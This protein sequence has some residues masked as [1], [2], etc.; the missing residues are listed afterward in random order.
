ME[1]HP[2]LR[3]EPRRDAGYGGRTELSA[4]RLCPPDGAGID[5]GEVRAGHGFLWRPARAGLQVGADGRGAAESGVLAVAQRHG[6]CADLGADAGAALASCPQRGEGRR[7]GPRLGATGAGGWA[8]RGIAR[9]GWRLDR[10]RS[11]GGTAA[12][13]GLGIEERP[14][15]GGAGGSWKSGDADLRSDVAVPLWG[16]RY[17][18]PSVLGATAALGGWR[19]PAVRHGGGA[20]GHGPVDLRAGTTRGGEGAADGCRIPRVGEWQGQSDP[21]EGGESGGLRSFGIPEGFPGAL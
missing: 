5:S 9:D 16:G 8:G 14:G 19:K 13:E 6:E 4:A 11:R 12:A 1:D 7:A 2:R 15:G 20:A 18:S 10:C 21:D 3:G 17:L